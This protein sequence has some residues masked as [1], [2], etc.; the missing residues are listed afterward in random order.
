MIFN[1]L[2]SI[3][4][5]GLHRLTMLSMAVYRPNPANMRMSRTAITMVP[6]DVFPVSMLKI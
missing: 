4:G 1:M 6:L 2:F 3:S 5:S